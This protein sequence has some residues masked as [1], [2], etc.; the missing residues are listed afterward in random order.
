MWRK[1]DNW[2]QKAASPGEVVIDSIKKKAMHKKMGSHAHLFVQ[3][4]LLVL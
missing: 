3:D 1:A 2:T 4:T